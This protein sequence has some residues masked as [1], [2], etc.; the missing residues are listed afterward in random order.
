MS[1]DIV[2]ERIVE[3]APEP[4][5]KDFSEEYV[6][7]LREEAAGWRIK[8]RELE[9]NQSLLEVKT[10]LTRR[11]I[12]CDPAWVKLT[13]GQSVALAVDGFLT[14]YPELKTATPDSSPSDIISRKVEVGKMP[15][16]ASSD[17]ASYGFESKTP[18]EML[19]TRQIE[20]IKKD[21]KA[22]SLLRKEYRGM[23]ASQGHRSSQEE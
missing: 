6:R 2:R 19:K 16:P 5:K 12:K 20:E 21:P 22:R 13:E 8:Y 3:K 18:Q 7:S 11:G 9:G 1:E 23:L 17:P 15:K 4:T 14:E 10:E